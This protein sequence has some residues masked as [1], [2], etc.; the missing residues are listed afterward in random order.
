ML[1]DVSSSACRAARTIA[2][3]RPPTKRLR[4]VG[5]RLNESR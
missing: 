2:G 1:L 5:P 4:R 3:W